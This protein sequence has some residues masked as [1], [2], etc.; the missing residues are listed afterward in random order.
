M[1]KKNILEKLKQIEKEKK[2]IVLLAVESGS[3]AWGIES[4]DSDYD[5]RFIF[6]RKKN[7]YLSLDKKSDVIELNFENGDFV[8]FDVFKFLNL[9]RNSNPSV[10]EWV[11]SSYSLC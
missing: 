3:R 1:D 9:L 7:E 10:I 11:F 6:K 4:Y 8:G 5:I 2:V